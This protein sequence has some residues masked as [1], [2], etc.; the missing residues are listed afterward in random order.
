[1]RT[2]DDEI[3]DEVQDLQD[4][5]GVT[6]AQ[7]NR[8]NLQEA[9]QQKPIDTSMLDDA[10][11][12]ARYRQIIGALTGL[13]EGIG[14]AYALKGGVDIGKGGM[15]EKIIESARDD[16][17]DA[18]KNIEAQ[19][20]RNQELLKRAQE[21]YQQDRE[22]G[23]KESAEK[24]KDEE[25]KFKTKQQKEEFEES[26]R[27]TDA[28]IKQ[29]QTAADKAGLDVDI[30]KEWNNPKSSVSRFAQNRYLSRNPKV[31]PE[32]I[33]NIS[34][35]QLQDLEKL[36]F[37]ALKLKDGKE[38]ADLTPAQ[39][40]V[41]EAFAKQYAEYV[42][43]GKGTDI[44][45]QLSE[46]KEVKDTLGKRNITGPVVGRVPDFIQA[47][48]NPEAL[49]ARDTV[50][51]VIQRSLRETLGAQFT[52]KEAERLISRAYNPVLSEE[53]NEKRLT[54]LIGQIEKGAKERERAMKYYEDKGTLKGFKGK[55]FNSADDF[56]LGDRKSVP[57]G[58]IRV[59]DPKSGKMAIIPKNKLK[60][61]LERGL[62][63][64]K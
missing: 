14:R 53:E 56:D 8:A 63:E 37:K 38:V 12:S 23:L 17:T 15:G 40:K 7:L 61:A 33:A 10:Q 6:N 64:V 27:K 28:Y 16:I 13:G 2:L 54:R 30:K 20:K 31:S 18:R 52:E 46:L 59:R 49:A 19:K 26:K 22:F 43:K 34:A 21:M 3:Q 44:Q 51:N 35:A 36:D 47:A 42:G 58:K 9:L 24:R 5:E 39:K 41:D 55:L 32:Q 4:Q 25:F 29:V 48:I 1:M 62:E 11:K 57:E 60:Q 50:E 45:K